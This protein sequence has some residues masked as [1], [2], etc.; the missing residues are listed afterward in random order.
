M[1]ALAHEEGTTFDWLHS[2]ML[3]A[4]QWQM[5]PWGPHTAFPA[6]LHSSKG[7]MFAERT[8]RMKFASRSLVKQ[9]LPLGGRSA[10]SASGGR[11]V[12]SSRGLPSSGT[13][14][15]VS[16]GWAR[17]PNARAGRLPGF[18]SRCRGGG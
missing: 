12:L 10:G 5:C 3:L 2:R 13:V 14:F 15:G 11:S 4:V 8:Q 18:G 9:A 17:S 16:A 1:G 7:S 6:L